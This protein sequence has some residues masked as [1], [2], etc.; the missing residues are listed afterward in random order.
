MVRL[1]KSILTATRLRSRVAVRQM[2]ALGRLS[3]TARIANC[4]NILNKHLC[5]IV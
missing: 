2:I 5:G 1:R 4:E 3:F